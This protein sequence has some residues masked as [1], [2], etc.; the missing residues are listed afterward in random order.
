VVEFERP[1]RNFS[2]EAMENRI[3]VIYFLGLAPGL[4]EAIVPAYLVCWDA[5]ALKARVAFGATAQDSLEYPATALE[6]RYAK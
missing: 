1:T 6:R 3:P 2:D 4:Y 5:R